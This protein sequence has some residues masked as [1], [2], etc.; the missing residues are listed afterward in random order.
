LSLYALASFGFIVLFL[1][2]AG[3]GKTRKDEIATLN[4]QIAKLQKQLEGIELTLAQ[5]QSSISYIET[6]S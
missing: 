6:Q 5:V 2:N 1:Q 4:E 3:F